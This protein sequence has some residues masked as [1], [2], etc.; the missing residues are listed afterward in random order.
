M[1]RSAFWI[2]PG[3]TAALSTALYGPFGF[4][5][6]FGAFII[7]LMIVLPAL[8]ILLLISGAWALLEP[9]PRWRTGARS[10]FIAV[11]APAVLIPAFWCFGDPLRD[12]ARYA[13][14]SIA[15]AQELDAARRK[16]G[17]FKHWDNW[18]MAGED[19]DAYLASDPTDTLARPGVAGRW[20]KAHR[21]GC[22]IVSTRRMGRGVYLL[23]TSNCPLVGAGI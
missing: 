11:L 2:A 1:K 22:D 12:P 19:N 23:T 16:D 14:W 8:G 15:H 20:A 18:G 9:R 13:V 6:D 17:V 21:L 5:R 3:I 10:F 7:G 4:G